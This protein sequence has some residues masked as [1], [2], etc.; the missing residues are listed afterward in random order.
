ML[1]AG[2][3]PLIVARRLLVFA[4][5]DVGNAEPRGLEVAIST[6]LA[7]ERIGMPEGRI[8]LAQA[9]TFLAC[10]PKSNAS[11]LAMERARAAVADSGS[12]PVPMHL[13]NAPTP[14]MKGMGYGRNYEYPHD[15]PD[16]FVSATNLP[17][18]LASSDFY[19]PRLEGAEG[20]IAERLKRWRQR[21]AQAKS[22]A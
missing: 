19:Q 6:F 15:A 14:L 10:A 2:E 13:R 21:R 16:R 17:E 8:V 3:Y 20:E 11:Y 4:S 12:L 5:E 9:I 1:D 7:V 18:P 22:R